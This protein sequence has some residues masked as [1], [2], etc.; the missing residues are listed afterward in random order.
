MTLLLV[1]LTFLIINLTCSG[2]LISKIL[3]QYGFYIK[4]TARL[5][6]GY[7]QVFKITLRYFKHAIRRLTQQSLKVPTWSI[8]DDLYELTF[9][10]EDEPCKV[11]LQVNHKVPIKVT[12][13]DDLDVTRELLPYF[14][15]TPIRL[16]SDVY[17]EP[18]QVIF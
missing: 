6:G 9:T 1:N 17:G 4:I 11:L 18:F 14:K 5:L 7:S 12:C 15:F 2:F 8:A 10:Y 3:Y 13:V 16:T